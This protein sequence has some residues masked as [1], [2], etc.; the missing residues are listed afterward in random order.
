MNLKINLILLLFL[1]LP[2]LSFGQFPGRAGGV[3][4]FGGGGAGSRGLGGNT[5]N[6]TNRQDPNNTNSTPKKGKILDDSTKLIYGPK[7]V[8]FFREADIFNNRKILYEIDTLMDGLHL[9]GFLQTNNYQIQ[10][11]GN[12]GTATRSVFYTP[13]S[14]IGTQLGYNAYNIYSTKSDLVNYYDTKSPFTNLQY[15]TGGNGSQKLLFDF[16][17]SV[18]ARWN[19]G[20]HLNTFTG[21]KQYGS[22][23]RA[24]QNSTRHWD[25]VFYS[26]Y[27]SKDSNYTVLAN[28]NYVTHS[29]NDDGGVSITSTLSGGI[30]SEDPLLTTAKTEEKRKQLHVYQ[31]YS[32][33]NG[34]QVYH[35][36]DVVRQNNIFNDQNLSQGFEAKIYKSITAADTAN[37]KLGSDLLFRK[38]RLVENKIGL[39]GFIN[40]FNYRI[41]YRN[42]DYKLIDSLDSHYLPKSKIKRNESFLGAWI[43]YYFKD[44][45][46]AFAETEYRIGK[47]FNF[48]FEYLRKHL[49]LGYYNVLA[50]PTLIQERFY[51]SVAVWDNQFKNTF[52]TSFYGKLKYV[53]KKVE[54]TPSISYSLLNN[55]IYFDTTATPKQTNKLIT[56]L[57]TGGGIS[58]NKGKF[59]TI[60]QL[61]INAK[62][63]PDLIRFPTLFLNSRVAYNFIYAKILHMQLG[64]EMHYKSAYY[65]DGYMPATQQFYLQDKKK[66]SPGLIA[67]VFL[68][69]KLNR[70][71]LMVKYSQLNSLILGDYYVG[72][73][74]KGLKGGIGFGV[75]WPLFD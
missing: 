42:R 46:K 1:L 31:Q 16:S 39:K 10:D 14:Q 4:G 24:G 36:L 64:L 20:V 12:I 47:D 17:R 61:F 3:G 13:I 68:N 19:V 74:F 60:N 25:A 15:A 72:Y 50:S 49:N 57:Q 40:G 52:S 32:L 33:A 71:R 51:S 27:F 58:F 53:I 59:S 63:G 11:L 44:S 62:T 34:F 29:S 22:L 69:M 26:S 2:V 30:A 66:I 21:A 48:R 73:N 9:F 35:I 75:S 55:T 45:T 5:N 56:V 43:N 7:T 41:H 28:Y 37:N 38:Y 54:F 8:R 65:A 6:Q 70:V 67:D 18:N 23:G